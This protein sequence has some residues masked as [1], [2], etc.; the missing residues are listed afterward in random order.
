MNRPVDPR[1][2]TPA[3][4][5][6]QVGGVDV[7]KPPVF[8]AGPAVGCGK[9]GE[10]RDGALHGW[11]N[12]VAGRP[13]AMAGC[14]GGDGDRVE[15]FTDVIW[16]GRPGEQGVVDR[17]RV[18]GAC[19]FNV[20]GTSWRLVSGRGGPVALVAVEV[21]AVARAGSPARP[22]HTHPPLADPVA[23]VLRWRWAR[24]RN[25]LVRGRCAWL[26]G[27][28]FIA[29]R[30]VRLGD[31]SPLRGAWEGRRGRAPYVLWL[32][33]KSELST[34]CNRDFFNR[35]AEVLVHLCV[36]FVELR[37]RL[38]LSIITWNGGGGTSPTKMW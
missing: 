18:L 31:W 25:E 15:G 35:G 37:S 10:L 20:P 26:G 27:Q 3:E 21:P 22:I 8:A 19:G 30:T 5:V 13:L 2:A 12:A 32:F 17:V 9:E 16:P 4:S 1:E 7:V 33:G 24:W 34:G 29:R 6:G 36:G 23:T 11:R 38:R 14:C 28:A